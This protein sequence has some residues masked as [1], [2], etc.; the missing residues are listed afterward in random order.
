MKIHVPARSADDWRSLLADPEKHWETGY[1][2]K[3]LAYCWQEAAGFPPCVRKAFESSK[4]PV[5]QDLTLLQAIPEVKVDLPG[6]RAASQTD[7]FALG[8]SSEGLVVI[9]VE[10][11][12]DEP[13][14][15]L[16]GEWLAAGGAGKPVRLKYLCERLGVA[17]KAIAGCRYQLLHRTVSALLLAEQYHAPTALMLVHSFSPKKLWFDDYASFAALLGVQAK[18]DAV[19]LVGARSAR[20]LLLGWACGDQ[21]FRSR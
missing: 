21:A 5:L 6:G 2:A 18:P 9:A 7:L 13:F 3:T 4:L 1:S 11:K 14:G 19:H 17:E 20:Q 8:R 16:V 15:P 10:G 12:V